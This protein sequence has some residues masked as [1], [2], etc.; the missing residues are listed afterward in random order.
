[1][2]QTTLHL[3]STD[4]AL[5]WLRQWGITSLTVDSRQVRALAAE[6]VCFIAWPGAARDGRAFV[7]QALKDGARACLV[8]AD[9][10]QAFAFADARVAALP[11]LKARSA[12]IAHGF[13]AEPSAELDVVAVTGTN[14]KTSTSWWTAQALTALGRGC[15][16]I[17]TL[18][19]GQVG[20]GEFKPTGLTTPDPITLHATFR[21]FVDQGLKAAAIEASS[22]GIEELRLHATHV[23]VAQFTN[24]TQDHLDYHGSMEAY[25]QA[26]RRLF[27]WPGLQAAVLNLDDPMG[28]ALQDH[29]RGRRLACWSYG[30][31]DVVRLQAAHIRYQQQGIVFDLIERD[32]A[33]SHEIGRA[34]VHAPVIGT[35]NVSNLLAVVGA[36]R[37]LDVP[38]V[39]AARVCS[40]LQPVPG[41][42]QIVASPNPQVEL[43]TV[44]V[45][46]AHTPDALHKALQALRPVAEARGGRLWCVFGCGGDRD[47]IKRPLMGA[48]AEQHAD[49]VVLTSDNP[50][51]EPPAFILSQILAGVAGRDTVDVIED[52]HA[53][54]A[55]VLEQADACDVVLIAG[56]GHEATQD[57]AGVKTPFSD[58]DEA[59][60]ALKRRAPAV[61]SQVIPMMMTLGLAHELLPGSVLSGDPATPIARVHT[62]TRTVQP[63]D[64]FVALRGERFDAHDFLPQAK[65]AGAVAVLAQHGV[66]TCGLPGL[67]VPDTRAALGWLASGWRARFDIPLIGVTGSNG[68]TTVTQMIASIL[69]A[70]VVSQGAPEASLATQGNFNNEIGVPL[71]L[72]RLREG[73][74]RCAVVEL[75]MNHPG[76]IAQLAAIAAPT[77][78]LVNNAQREHQEFMHTVEAVA[79]ENG[80]VLQALSR[81]G[82][83]VFPADDEFAAIWREQA[84]GYPKFDFAT[85]GAAAVTG[86]ATWMA[87]PTPHWVIEISTAQGAALVNLKMA[88]AHNVRN[89]LASTAAALGA[90]VP[91]PMIAQGLE[92]F[93]PVKGRSQLRCVSIEGR[94]VT[95]VDDSYNANPDSVRAAIDMLAGLPAPR[96]LVLGDM[97]EVGTQGPA[98][99]AE[100]GAYARERGIEH[101]WTAGE[102]CAHAAQAY[103]GH[104]G[105]TARHFSSAADIVAALPTLNQAPA[106]ASVLVKGSRFMKME[107][108]VAVLSAQVGGAHAA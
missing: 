47:P 25:W 2:S 73:Q 36:L 26:K 59:A 57:V 82:V 108:V 86:R 17:G 90:G 35:F 85:Q 13:Y 10:V 7:E 27:D 22:I 76:E 44:V 37:A 8:E 61:P 99:H 66:D 75:G 29:A 79:R 95:L 4:E 71:T 60:A 92:A 6:G 97:G 55:H 78:G 96:W 74:H 19:V 107:Q 3:R 33:L 100:V 24:F 41:R 89:A 46:Y 42:M 88:G 80:S 39:D 98:F 53:A 65:A 87:E 64:L 28:H 52:R 104:Q 9:G 50:R 58:V 63:G 83:A 15:G 20:S 62:D 105:Q 5:S 67:I 14:G 40:G 1:M 48:M 54:I 51:S 45:D 69:K 12:E 81:S 91:L 102:L 11:G 101:V 23:K 93:E 106:A 103:G 32:E 70:W 16:V 56:K 30:L 34:T 38:L 21:D 68:K 77:V 43:P 94:P 84:N 72:L 31:Q 18:G 49:R